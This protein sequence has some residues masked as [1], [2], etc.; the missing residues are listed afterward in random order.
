M[1]FGTVGET[2]ELPCSYNNPT[3]GALTNATS[4]GSAIRLCGAAQSA[5]AVA[6]PTPLLLTHADFGAGQ[7]YIPVDTTGFDPGDYSVRCWG[8]I[9]GVVLGG[10]TEDFKLVAANASTKEYDLSA[11]IDVVNSQTSFKLPSGV[12]SPNSN[13][14]PPGSKVIFRKADD[15][16]DVC[17]GTL[18]SYTVSGNVGTVVIEEDPGVFPDPFIESGDKLEID[19]G[20]QIRRKYFTVGAGATT[21]SVPTDLAETDNNFWKGA[22]VL[23]LNDPNV[24]K[25]PRAVTGYNGS[26][27]AL[28]VSE[29]FTTALSE[30]TVCKLIFE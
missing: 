10:V 21:T 2:L 4:L 25:Q 6:T 24:P 23:P 19:V 3:T 20:T 13:A 29:P 16:N 11:T 8:T 30:N 15:G 18:L 5:A 17:F 1:K 26:S 22:W 14:Y 7:G 28:S 9:G 12:G 27:K